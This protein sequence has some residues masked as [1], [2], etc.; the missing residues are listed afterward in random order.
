MNDTVKRLMGLADDYAY[1]KAEAM[2]NQYESWHS[3]A[4]MRQDDAETDESR[5]ALEDELVRLFTPL[6]DEQI[7]TVYFG[8]TEQSL[9]PQDNVLA[10]KFARAIE[11]QHGITGETK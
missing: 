10:H 9:R 5:Q 2:R 6:S 8:A 3:R 11:F 7:A 1:N 4:S